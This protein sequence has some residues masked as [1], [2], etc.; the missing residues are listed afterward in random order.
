[1]GATQSSLVSSNDPTVTAKYDR[2][3]ILDDASQLRYAVIVLATIL[4]TAL[5]AMLA[6]IYFKAKRWTAKGAKAKEG[7]NDELKKKLKHAEEGRPRP[8]FNGYP[9]PYG[10]VPQYYG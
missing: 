1:M 10:S 3:A 5:A 9:H 6:F 4:G 2:F 7:E 8:V